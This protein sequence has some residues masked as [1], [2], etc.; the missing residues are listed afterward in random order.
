M[1]V[2]DRQLTA[3]VH[4]VD[5]RLHLAR[6]PADGR[7]VAFE[8]TDAAF[9]FAVSLEIGG[10]AS[11]GTVAAPRDEPLHLLAPGTTARDLYPPVSQAA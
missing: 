2:S 9:A 7:V 11:A 3:V 10:V 4:L 8:E 6:H 1:D 5:S